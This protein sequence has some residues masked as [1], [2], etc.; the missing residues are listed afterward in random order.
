MI[1]KISYFMPIQ[2]PGAVSPEASP[3]QELCK[4]RGI[5]VVSTDAFCLQPWEFLWSFLGSGHVDVIDPVIYVLQADR[6]VASFDA[7]ATRVI[8]APLSSMHQGMLCETKTL[9]H[10]HGKKGM[11]IYTFA[12]RL[13][14]IIL[15][16]R[17]ATELMS[18][19]L[20][21][22]SLWLACQ[23]AVSVHTKSPAGTNTQ[24]QGEGQVRE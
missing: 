16:R 15:P 22:R 17:R 9:M 19:L 24:R 2:V 10:H 1:L 7:K 14:S 4:C 8:R 5:D 6:A 11:Q 13:P 12:I 23:W 18:E 3:W 20:G 21:L